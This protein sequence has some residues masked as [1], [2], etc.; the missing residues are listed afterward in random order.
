VM[1]GQIEVP[2]A[3][4]RLTVDRLDGTLL[5]I[6]APDVGKTTFARYLYR[7]LCARPGRVAFLDGDLG[8]STLGPPATMT[9]AVGVT[10][11]EAFPPR[12][13]AWRRFVGSI[14][15]RGHMLPLLTG[16]A[17]LARAA[18]DA[19]V[20]TIVYDTTGL[21]DSAQGGLALKLAKVDLLR[22]TTIFA[23]QRGWELEPLL[24]P[25][26]LSR[27]VRTV[28][29]G[30]SPAVQSRDV[31]RRQAYRA[32]RFASYFRGTAVSRPLPVGWS[33]LAILP[34]P[35]FTPHRL[36]AFEDADGFTLGLGI[37]MEAD[38]RARQVT[39]YTPVASLE[40]VD[41]LRLGDVA[42]DP[43]TFRD[44]IVSTS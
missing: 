24:V 1:E 41:A 13:R 27:R 28:D 7:R 34:G 19:G 4:E 21:V 16:A 44:Q 30:R 11:E 26:R 12:G 18:M 39:V 8:Q 25:L 35:H 3:W 42:V 23:I 2:P 10:G 9:L 20:E 14:S 33:R 43:Q 37:V 17:R 5:V 36:L 31:P 32:A 22:P 29:L 38:S 40:G 6:G 15:P